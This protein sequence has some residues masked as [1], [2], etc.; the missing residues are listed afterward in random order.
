MN[1]SPIGIFDSG[2]GGLSVFSELIK[3]LPDENYIYFGDTLNS[4]YGTK[5][6]EQL[7][8]FTKNIFDFFQSKEVKAVVMACNTTSALTYDVFKEEY[9]FKIYPIV[10]NVSAY[11]ADEGYNRIGVFATN[12]T[13]NAHAYKNEIQKYNKNIQVFET[14][15]PEWV[16]IVEK[17]L[18]YELSSIGN[19]KLYIDKMMENNPEKIILGCTH[20]PYLMSILSK[21]APKEMFINPAVYFSECICNDLDKSDLLN[22][23]RKYEPKFY[24]SSNPEQ[25]K[26]A[27]KLFYNVEKA[28][29]I[30]LV[31]AEV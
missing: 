7:I 17:S 24:V 15:C 29:E 5:S 1:N 2:V 26:T 25:F 22:N 14:A 8:E 30:S 4:P 11:I 28:E 20:Y 3:L 9:G 23:K 31:K 16:P 19:I 21:F 12:A 10:Q 6:K 13:I 27:S 18:M